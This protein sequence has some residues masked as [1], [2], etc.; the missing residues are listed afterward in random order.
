[1]AQSALPEEVCLEMVSKKWQYLKGVWRRLG[2]IRT[3]VIGNYGDGDVCFETA[4][5]TA[6]TIGNDGDGDDAPRR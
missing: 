6:T 3:A 5:E 4:T 2:R 1:M